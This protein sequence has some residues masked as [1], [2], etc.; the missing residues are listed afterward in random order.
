MGSRAWRE[1]IPCRRLGWGTS[2]S[3]GA[4]CRGSCSMRR[5]EEDAGWR[6]DGDSD[7]RTGFQTVTVE[8]GQRMGRARCGAAQE[9]SQSDAMRCDAGERVWEGGKKK[10][11]TGPEAESTHHLQLR[12]RRR[13]FLILPGPIWRTRRGHC[14][15][16]CFGERRGAGDEDGPDA[17]AQPA[18]FH[19]HTETACK[20]RSGRWVRRGWSRREINVK[21]LTPPGG[22]PLPASPDE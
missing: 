3:E 1:G 11:K 5:S 8:D 12:Y 2:L 21:Q 7:G 15:D 14:C 18:Q 19:T 13:L 9:G 20:W 22:P 17:V 16:Y 4:A 6:A 10:R